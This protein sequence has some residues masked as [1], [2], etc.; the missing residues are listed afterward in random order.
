MKFV[1]IARCGDWKESNAIVRGTQTAWS[2]LE[3]INNGNFQQPQLTLNTNITIATASMTITMPITNKM[4][5]TLLTSHILLLVGPIE[6]CQM[7]DIDDGPEVASMLHDYSV[8]AQHLREL[9]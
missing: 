1:L 7:N 4:E 5:V 3:A 9:K 2:A 6:T 8:C